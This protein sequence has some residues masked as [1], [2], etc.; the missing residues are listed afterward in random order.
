MIRVEKLVLRLGSFLLDSVSFEVETG[1]Y[2]VLMGKTGCGKTSVIE[3]VCGLRP[4]SVGRIQ[5]M[6]RDVTALGPAE[7]GV[8]YVP[9]DGV[10]FPTLTVYEHL[11]FALEIRKRPKDEIEY[12]VH[13]LAGLLGIES[14]LPRKPNGLSGGERQ[15]V[16]V[17]RAL[18][19]RPP[20]L[21]LD[22]PLSA[23]DKSTRLG[24][25]D[26]LNTVKE[27]YGVTTLHV[28]HDLDEATRLADQ[29]I[30]LEDGRITDR[31]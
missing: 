20:I 12:R 7:R 11:A 26:L 18:A 13:E 8:G 28:T 3:A 10:L 27:E 22:E 23:L 2:A 21:C 1:A 6:G 15:R 9:Q 14:L 30:H 16:A 29:F 24:I 25:C 31:Q 19:F 4:T 5:L 17:G